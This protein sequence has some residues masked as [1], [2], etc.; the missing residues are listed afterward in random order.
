[1]PKLSKIFIEDACILF[2]LL[3]LNL[4]DEFFLLEC[5]VFTTPQ[6]LKEIVIESQLIEINK[7]IKKGNLK[8]DSLGTIES[9]QRLFIENDGL[10]FT[11]CSVLELA[12][13]RNGVLLTADKRLRN[14]AKRKSLEVRGML[15]VIEWMYDCN[16]IDGKIALEKLKMYPGINKRLPLKEFND[17]YS[18]FTNLYSQDV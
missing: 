10:S 1:M 3:D 4:I 15:W 7:H 5:E 9:I 16:I 14:E 11:D 2:D 13:R 12:T 6:V 17:L 18:K 8:V